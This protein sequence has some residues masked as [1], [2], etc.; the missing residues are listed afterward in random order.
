MEVN[1]SYSSRL[2]PGLQVVFRNSPFLF[3]WIPGTQSSLLL[4]LVNSFRVSYFRITQPSHFH[5]KT[6]SQKYNLTIRPTVLGPM[7]LWL[8]TSGLHLLGSRGMC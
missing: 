7:G 6:C 5:F 2:K 8:W 1:A 4:D 3:N